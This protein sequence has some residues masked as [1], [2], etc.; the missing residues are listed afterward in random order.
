MAAQRGNA[1]SPHRE[2]LLLSYEVGL[3]LF[4]VTKCVSAVQ[5]VC[6]TVQAAAGL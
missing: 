4:A 2:E 3:G 5:R 1:S 6:S